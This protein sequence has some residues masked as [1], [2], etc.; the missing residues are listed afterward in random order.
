M[1]H[2]VNRLSITNFMLLQIPEVWQNP[3]GEYH[4]GLIYAYELFPKLLKE[5]V[6]K[7]RREKLWDPQQRSCTTAVRVKL[8]TFEAMPADTAKVKFIVM[9]D[10]DPKLLLLCRESIINHYLNHNMFTFSKHISLL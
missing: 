2:R 9:T 1:L 5:R 4:L 3:S 7:E 6:V 8:D 10:F